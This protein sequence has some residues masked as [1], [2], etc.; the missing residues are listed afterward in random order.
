MSPEGLVLLERQDQVTYLCPCPSDVMGEAAGVGGWSGPDELPAGDGATSPAGKR[1]PRPLRGL[2]LTH[3]CPPNDG[4]VRSFPI[5]QMTRPRLRRVKVLPQMVTSKLW[6]HWPSSIRG[7]LDDW[8]VGVTSQSRLPGIL[9]GIAM[10]VSWE[11][12]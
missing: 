7:L 2:L 9:I 10:Q 5:S 6:S 11:S 1:S 12:P 4:L 8:T 3:Q